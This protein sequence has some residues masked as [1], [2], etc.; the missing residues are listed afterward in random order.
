MVVE[1]HNMDM[2][3]KEWISNLTKAEVNAYRF[4]S[5]SFFPEA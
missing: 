4:I 5:A 1:Q 2:Y 3:T